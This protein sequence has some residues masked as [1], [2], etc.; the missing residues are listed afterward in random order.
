MRHCNHLAYRVFVREI[1]VG[2]NAVD[3]DHGLGVGVVSRSEEP[4]LK[5]LARDFGKK[6]TGGEM[7]I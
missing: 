6:L 7:Q 1:G 2:K 4:A 5:K 3:H